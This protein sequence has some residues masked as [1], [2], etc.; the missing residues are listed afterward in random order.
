[1]MPVVA[2]TSCYID[3]GLK[4]IEIVFALKENESFMPCRQIKLCHKC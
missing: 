1:M 3:L 4:K 2:R